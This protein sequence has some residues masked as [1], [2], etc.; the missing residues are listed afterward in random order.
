MKRTCLAIVLL[1]SP[2]LLQAQEPK[3][4]R[5]KEQDGQATALEVAV[6]RYV[7]KDKTVTV[8]LIRTGDIAF[9]KP[10]VGT[11]AMADAIIKNL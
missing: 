3:F 11:K 8:D 5:L 2:S 6:T 4:I 10:S 9:G 1:I 7:N